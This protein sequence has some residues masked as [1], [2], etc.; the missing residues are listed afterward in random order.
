MKCT[1]NLNESNSSLVHFITSNVTR[2]QWGPQHTARFD[3]SGKIEKVASWHVTTMQKLNF[4][5]FSQIH[6]N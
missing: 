3:I 5:Y 6:K 2:H 4:V 1:E